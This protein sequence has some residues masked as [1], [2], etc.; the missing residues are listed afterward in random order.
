MG[1]ILKIMRTFRRLSEL[2]KVPNLDLSKELDIIEKINLQDIE[3]DDS[4]M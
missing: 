2:E 4:V 3:R 1:V